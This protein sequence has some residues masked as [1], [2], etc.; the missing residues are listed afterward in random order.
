MYLIRAWQTGRRQRPGRSAQEADRI[1]RREKCGWWWEHGWVCCAARH[2]LDDSLSEL[3]A[4]ADVRVDL[5]CAAGRLRQLP[6][7][8]DENDRI[9]AVRLPLSAQRFF[10]HCDPPSCRER[11]GPLRDHVWS[12]NKL[13]A[14]R[15]RAL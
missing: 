2:E 9:G 5:A 8:P 1:P 3:A 14:T 6:S 11:R 12:F 7:L 13:L 4:V 15:R 10:T